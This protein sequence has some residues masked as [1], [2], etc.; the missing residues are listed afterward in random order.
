MPLSACRTSRRSLIECLICTIVA[1]QHCDSSLVFL[2]LLCV[3]LPPSEAVCA[4]V[5]V[6]LCVCEINPVAQINVFRVSAVV[7][8]GLTARLPQVLFFFFSL[9]GGF[10]C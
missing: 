7:K 2:R 8:C 6:R 5:C 4:C 9:I 1:R 10:V 3:V